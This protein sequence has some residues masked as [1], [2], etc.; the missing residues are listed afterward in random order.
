MPRA[1]P[2]APG[3]C[4]DRLKRADETFFL[5]WPDAIALRKAGWPQDVRYVRIARPHFDEKGNQVVNP[6]NLV[7][8]PTVYDLLALILADG[9]ERDATIALAKVFTER[10]SKK[11]PRQLKPEEKAQRAK[12][13]DRLKDR[14]PVDYSEAGIPHLIED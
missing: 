1:V 8:I 3:F 12:L 13:A 11:T 14:G 6:A 9:G 7:A 10:R 2:C 4:E 5:P